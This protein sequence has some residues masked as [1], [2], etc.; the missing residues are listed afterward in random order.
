FQAE[1]LAVAQIP[2]ALAWAGSMDSGP[3][4]LPGALHTCAA[5]KPLSSDRP[6]SPGP[7]TPDSACKVPGGLPRTG[8]LPPGRIPPLPPVAHRS[9][10]RPGALL[11]RQA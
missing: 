9:I 4:N 7:G 3:C 5:A 2:E 8:P 6:E 11:I 1:P 10:G